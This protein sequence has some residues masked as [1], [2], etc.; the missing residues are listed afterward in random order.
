MENVP[1]SDYYKVS[2]RGE[3][4]LSILIERM[5]RAGL[6]G[7]DHQG[8][9]ARGLRVADQRL[10]AG[11]YDDRLDVVRSAE[12]EELSSAGPDG[13]GVDEEAG[14]LLAGRAAARNNLAGP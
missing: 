2:G 10:E 7:G 6:E 1:N 3:L 14:D 5:R 8:V 11:G 12:I 13:D 4:H 9:A